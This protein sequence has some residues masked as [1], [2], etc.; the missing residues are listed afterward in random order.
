MNLKMLV[1]PK[2]ISIFAGERHTLPGRGTDPKAFALI[3]SLS[4][5]N[6]AKSKEN[7]LEKLIRREE[8]QSR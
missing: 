4:G 2:S 8:S 7:F 3:Y 6:L 5:N 1:S